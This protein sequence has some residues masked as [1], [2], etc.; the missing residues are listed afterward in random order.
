MDLADL[1]RDLEALREEALASVAAAADAAAL[2]SLELE[3]LGK[4]GRLTTVLR[5]IEG[6]GAHSR[7]HT[8]RILRLSEDL[9]IVIE[10]VDRAER[11]DQVLPLLDEMIGEG[12]IT[13]E[14]VQVLKYRPGGEE[15]RP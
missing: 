12:L 2:A 13:I 1:T 9:P 5:G 14:K 6:F 10:I 15:E 3:V 7:I 4:K 11:I 8:S